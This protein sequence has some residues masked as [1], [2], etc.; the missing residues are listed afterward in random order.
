MY[1]PYYR[2][3]LKHKTWIL[4]IITNSKVVYIGLRTQFI[5]KAKKEKEVL[6]K[7]IQTEN[8]MDIRYIFKIK[9]QFI[10][11]KNF[12]R[13][14]LKKHLYHAINS[15]AKKGLVD[16]TYNP[17]GNIDDIYAFDSKKN[18][19]LVN[20]QNIQRDTNDAYDKLNQAKQQEREFAILGPED[21]LVTDKESIQSQ[22]DRAF[23]L[24]AVKRD[25]N[26]ADAILESHKKE[27]SKNDKND[28]NSQNDMKDPIYPE[29]NL[30]NDKDLEKS[31]IEVI[32]ID[33]DSLNSTN[34]SYNQ[35]KTKNQTMAKPLIIKPI[36]KQAEQSIENLN[37]ISS[38][39]NEKESD[40]PQSKC[41]MN[42]KC[43]SID[44]IEKILIICEKCNIDNKEIM[45]KINNLSQ[46]EFLK[47]IKSNLSKCDENILKTEGNNNI[48]EE[49]FGKIQDSNEIAQKIK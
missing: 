19:N 37:N 16:F 5:P 9:N 20:F 11:P 21:D 12:E 45:E 18:K 31:V 44:N 24:E 1:D 40:T 17:V 30:N 33:S 7:Y 34:D 39:L 46:T 47:E 41:K 26:E 35:Y 36:D 15:K 42:P 3:P 49:L 23:P 13:K 10:L 48:I 43:S 8:L 4:S 38:V 25:E 28:I 32:A 29:I 27:Y 2:R 14:N 6:I 22:L